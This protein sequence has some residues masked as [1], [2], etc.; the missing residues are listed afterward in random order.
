MKLMGNDIYC[1]CLQQ[2]LLCIKALTSHF[3]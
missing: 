2:V 3:K 1:G